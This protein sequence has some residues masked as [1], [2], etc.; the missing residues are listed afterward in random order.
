MLTTILSEVA[1][2]TQAIDR[3]HIRLDFLRCDVLLHEV[4]VAVEQ[5]RERVLST[6][7]VANLQ[8]CRYRYVRRLRTGA[9]ALI[10]FR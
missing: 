3:D 4:A 8:T 6:Q 7:S 1:H 10:F 9:N 2:T 5:E